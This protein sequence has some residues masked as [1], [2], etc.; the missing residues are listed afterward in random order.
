MN[1][2]YL[3]LLHV[4]IYSNICNMFSS[5]VRWNGEEKKEFLL[6]FPGILKDEVNFTQDSLLYADLFQYSVSQY[7]TLN[8]NSANTSMC[9]GQSFPVEMSSS[10]ALLASKLKA[11]WTN[12]YFCF[13]WGFKGSWKMWEEE[14][15]R[16]RRES[17]DYDGYYQQ[18]KTFVSMLIIRIV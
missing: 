17:E 11:V 7:K 18:G 15:K 9:G 13:N 14:A 10:K 1:Y 4:S 3:V 5:G 2:I 12:F 16:K 6:S 8:T